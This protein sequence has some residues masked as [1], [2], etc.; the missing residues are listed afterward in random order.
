MAENFIEE[1][2]ADSKIID[3][4]REFIRLISKSD[5]QKARFVFNKAAVELERLLPEYAKADVSA[6]NEL[7][8][9]AQKIGENW[10]DVSHI[11]GVINGEVIPKLYKYMS[12]FAGIEVEENGFCIK[13]SDSGFLTIKDLK[14]GLFLHDTHDP[15][16]EAGRIADVIYR[17]EMEEIHIFGCGLGYLPYKIWDRSGGAVDVYVYED[18]E[19]L[20]GYADAYGVLSW[21][22]EK[23][24]S[25]IT[26]NDENQVIDKFFSEV[27]FDSKKKCIY[28]TP[29]KRR[30][31]YE[32]FDGNFEYIAATLAYSWSLGDSLA[33][34]YWKNKKRPSV[35]F[36][37]LQKKLL[38]DE[39]IVVAA[40]P[41]LDDNLEFIRENVG[42]KKIVAVNT[43]MRRLMKENIRPDLFVV[44]DSNDQMVEHIQGTGDYTCGIPLVADWLTN[45]KYIDNYKG[46]ISFI[47]TPT[48][49][50]IKDNDEEI[51][52]VSGTVSTQAIE[53]AIRLGAKK[54]YLVGLDLSYP[55]GRNFAKGMPHDVTSS[56]KGGMEVPSNN[57]GM[58]QTVPMFAS[59]IKLVEQKIEKHKDVIFYNMSHDGAYIKGTNIIKV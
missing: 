59:Y 18:E 28:I 30:K 31:Y 38:G 48:D 51:W 47:Y 42:N 16:E 54:I 15:M 41:S 23:N 32:K 29:S 37:E 5:L 39:W 10:E 8:A 44:S 20:V 36:T 46:E 17:P 27:E 13:S 14:S 55:G 40:G 4:L 11:T 2:Y 34:H 22:D 57:G 7:Q 12:N 52:D 19:A 24:L 25:V 43:V 50:G 21:I 45:W 26:G 1:I 49:T 35:S 6:A 33:I 9:S 58:V 3:T 56:A 53:C